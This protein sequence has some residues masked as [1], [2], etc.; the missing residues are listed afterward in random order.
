MQ[1]KLHHIIHDYIDKL[2][3]HV[4]KSRQQQQQ[5]YVFKY[6]DSLYKE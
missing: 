4:N 1:T 5:Q 6:T 3:L 2:K